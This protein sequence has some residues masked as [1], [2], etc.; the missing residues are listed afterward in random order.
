[1][2]LQAYGVQATN[3]QL[4]TLADRLQGTTSYDDGVALDYLQAIAQRAGLRTDGLTTADG[5]YRTWSMADVIREVRRGYPVITLVHYATLPDHASSHSSSDHYVV[6]IGVT[7]QGFVVNDPAFTDN[8]GY[9]RLLTPD[10][11]INAWRAA[12]I[13]DQAVAFLPPV[14]KPNL[15][16]LSETGHPTPAPLVGPL[17]RTAAPTQTS[18]SPWDL[19]S[20]PSVAPARALDTSREA[21]AP[22][23]GPTVAAWALGLGQWRHVAGG[24]ATSAV[25]SPPTS[26]TPSSTAPGAVGHRTPEFPLP[27]L[28]VAGLI[29][30]GALLILTLPGGRTR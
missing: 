19:P 20:E 14:G 2:V 24:E 29:A 3:E 1:M 15:A 16:L 25:P 9:R 27:T 26:D 4:R 21:I 6:V 30:A 10:Q 11:L 7:D 28:I 17:Q 12:G 22:P 18:G 8:G 5:H 23:P 13:P